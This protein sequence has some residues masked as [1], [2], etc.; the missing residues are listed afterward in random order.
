MDVVNPKLRQ[1]RD[2]ETGREFS[3][4]ASEFNVPSELIAF[5]D[6][7]RWDIESEPNGVRE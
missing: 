5:I 4:M 3:F 7:L 6:K 2:L 1:Y